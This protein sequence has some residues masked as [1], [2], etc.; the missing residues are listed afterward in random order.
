MGAYVEFTGAGVTTRSAATL[1]GVSRATATRAQEP[2][3]EPFP[4][5]AS[6]PA[7]KLSLAERTRVLEVLDSAEFV[8]QAPLQVYAILLER[9]VYLC[10]VSTMYR[11]LAE[12]GQVTE[13]R[14]LTRHPARAVPELVA[15]GPGQVYSCYAEVVV[16]PSLRPNPWFR[17]LP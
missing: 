8:D 11:I 2:A 12:A 1:T 4:G 5:V 16:M 14:R 7:N 9:G 6:A 17:A 15:T 3:A 10:S 13:R